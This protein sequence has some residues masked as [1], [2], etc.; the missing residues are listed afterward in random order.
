VINSNQTQITTHH[1]GKY[2]KLSAS[3]ASVVWIYQKLSV[4]WICQTYYLG[5]ISKLF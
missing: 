1:L 5:L 4:V 3:N 2:Q